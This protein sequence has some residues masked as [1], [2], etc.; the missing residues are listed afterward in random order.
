MNL[1]WKPRSCLTA[2]TGLVVGPQETGRVPTSGAPGGSP[3]PHTAPELLS[4]CLDLL[5]H[6]LVDSGFL[7]SQWA[8]SRL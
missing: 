6:G 7:H 1:S 4:S 2:P 3:T 5:R 8:K